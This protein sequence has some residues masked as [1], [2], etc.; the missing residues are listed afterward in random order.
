MRDWNKQP[1]EEIRGRYLGE[2][3]PLLEAARPIESL[4]PER[5]KQVRRRVARTLFGTRHLGFRARLSPALAALALLVIGGAA[6]A[7]A[8]S[9]GFLPG[10]GNT[11]TG[12][13]AG[14]STQE[15]RKRKTARGR[16][17]SHPA[18]G[19]SAGGQAGGGL[20]QPSEQAP[21]VLPEVP[22]PLISAV[23]AAATTSVWAPLSDAPNR[24]T[25][26][27][28]AK[29]TQATQATVVRPVRRLAMA[30]SSPALAQSPVARVTPSAAVALPYPAPWGEAGRPEALAGG[31]ATQAMLPPAAPAPSAPAPV[32]AQPAAAAPSGAQS[33]PAQKSPGSDQALFGQ[34][35]RRLRSENNPGAA[36]AILQEHAKSYPRSAFAGERGA[37]EVEAMLALHRDREALNLL[38]GMVLD[39]LPRS[40][41]RFVVRG[42]LR[43]A[44]K[45]WQEASADFDRALARVSGAPAWHER[46]L[47]G[48]G[49]ARIR[50]GERE[51]GMADVER[52]HDTYPKGRFAAEAARFFP[53]K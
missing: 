7:T 44:A 21:V 25:P 53:K 28:A 9:L 8:Q 32:V 31:P 13:P 27:L 38:D 23:S 24:P 35:L 6:V 3:A 16:S 10:L 2:I 20:G 48:R 45:R 47:W 51:A 11:Q 33:P 18:V 40:G 41:E 52:Y 17:V 12:A 4:P 34:A 14:Q 26:R 50:L 39:D 22:D 5:K 36:L 49:V 29:A 43:A 15:A 46:A 37:L 1:S 30:T 19:D 42:E